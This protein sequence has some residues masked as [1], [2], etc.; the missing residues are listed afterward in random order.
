MKTQRSIIKER[1]KKIYD[2]L[3]TRGRISVADLAKM[4]NVTSQTIRR[5]LKILDEKNKL[6]MAHGQAIK[7][8]SLFEPIFQSRL[9]R[10]IEEKNIIGF[11]ATKLI[12]DNDTIACDATTTVYSFIHNL[13]N[14]TNLSVF[15]NSFNSAKE[16]H[17]KFLNNSI[18]GQVFFLGGEI[19]FS[20]SMT[21]G[22]WVD[23]ALDKLHFD[24]AI[25]GAGGVDLEHG[26]SA[27]SDKVG[28][29]ASK[30]MGHANKTI[31]LVDSTKIGKKTLYSFG[32][33]SQIDTIV[34][35]VNPPSK[36][37]EAYLSEHNINWIKVDSESL[38]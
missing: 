37:W 25:I 26:L 2:L 32:N 15:I 28:Y 16:I 30:I 13:N 34:T 5:D 17:D 19:D 23:Q 33:L 27:F 1:Q 24:K 22:H 35:T 6:Y 31:L 10:H 21:Y 36:E 11:E 38:D 20:D 4:L 9:E 18:S 14:K 7:N 12:K 3:N 29:F 8:E